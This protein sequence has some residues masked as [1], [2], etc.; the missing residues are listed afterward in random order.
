[1]LVDLKQIDIKN[2]SEIYDTESRDS[3]VSL[4]INLEKL[5]KDFLK[6]EKGH[7]YRF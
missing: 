2:L 6:N 1:M 7:V 5:M 3:F 4:Y